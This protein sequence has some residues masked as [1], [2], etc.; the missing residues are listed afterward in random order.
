MGLL[1]WKGGTL[2]PGP[3]RNWL[4][5]RAND[6]LFQKFFVC[7]ISRQSICF[8]T[9]N[10]WSDTTTWVLYGMVSKNLILKAGGGCWDDVRTGRIKNRPAGYPSKYLEFRDWIGTNFTSGLERVCQLVHVS[11]FCL[12]A[13][14]LKGRGHLLLNCGLRQ[15]GA[16]VCW[17][18]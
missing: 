4:W 6:K 1:W 8:D 17:P 3:P 7:M 11:N 12:K 14:K 5:I 2:L 13:Q 18:F 10:Y 9:G 15:E 16:L